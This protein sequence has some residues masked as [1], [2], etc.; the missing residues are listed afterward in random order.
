MPA[1]HDASKYFKRST[2]KTW[3]TEHSLW[4][5]PYIIFSPLKQ[6]DMSYTLS[7]LTTKA[8]CTALLNIA[9]AEKGSMVYRKTGLQRQT[10]N[11]TLTSMEI[12]ASMAAVDA[13]IAALTAILA[14]LPPG[15]TYDENEVRKTKAEYKKFLLEQRRGN[16]GPI[17]IVEKEFDIACLDG[18]IVE[19]EAFILALETRRGE[20]PV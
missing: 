3:S 19:T 12:E 14:T 10:Q 11:A 6:T 17:A 5:T 2:Y 8:D 16:Y 20:L 7:L 9:N 1:T 13:E 18:S 4:T 15:P